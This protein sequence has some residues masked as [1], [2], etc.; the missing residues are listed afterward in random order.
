MTDYRGQQNVTGV[1]VNHGIDIPRDKLIAV[2][3]EISKLCKEINSGK[4]IDEL[5]TESLEG[6]IRYIMQLN[7]G[8]GMHYMKRLH[9]LIKISHST[10]TCPN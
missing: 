10:E 2:R 8:A 6:K 4:R 1:N 7:R 9:K 5:T 3:A